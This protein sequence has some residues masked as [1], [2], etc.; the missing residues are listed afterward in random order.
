MVFDNSRFSDPRCQRIFYLTKSPLLGPQDGVRGG[1][2]D[3]GEGQTAF[4]G[5]CSVSGKCRFSTIKLK[6]YILP[7]HKSYTALHCTVG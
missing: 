6:I 1:T 4:H 3:K 2:D 5:S 7:L